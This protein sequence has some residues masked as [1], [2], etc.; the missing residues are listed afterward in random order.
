MEKKLQIEALKTE[1]GELEAQLPGNRSEEL[2]QRLQVKQAELHDL[3]EKEA[4]KYA[5]VTQRRLY[6]IG[7]KASKLL[8][9]LDKRDQ[10]QKGVCKIVDELGWSRRSSPEMAEAFASYYEMLYTTKT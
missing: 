2:R 3:A 5:Q 1:V 6:D 8:A 7:D 9:W 4:R 10:I